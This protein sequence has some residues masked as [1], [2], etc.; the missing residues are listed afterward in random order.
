MAS[1]RRKPSIDAVVTFTHNGEKVI[2]KVLTTKFRPPRSMDYIWETDRGD[3]ITT[4]GVPKDMKVLADPSP[5]VRSA[6]DRIDI[7]KR[8]AASV[9]AR[10]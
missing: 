3:R 6:A 7:A 5:G 9:M 2:A 4:R 8:V 10:L 1:R